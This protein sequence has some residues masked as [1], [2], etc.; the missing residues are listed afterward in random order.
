[1]IDAGEVCK[2][3]FSSRVSARTLR[4]YL[5]KTQRLKTTYLLDKKQDTTNAV[6]AK[7]DTYKTNEIP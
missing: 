5:P 3:V 7:P 1:L 4:F 6:L 2:V